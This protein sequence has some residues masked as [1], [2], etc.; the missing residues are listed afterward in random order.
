M[1]AYMSVPGQRHQDGNFPQRL[2][3]LEARRI[4]ATGDIGISYPLD[5]N[6]KIPKHNQNTVLH[7]LAEALQAFINSPDPEGYLISDQPMAG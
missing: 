1:K 2:S 3:I 6:R 7:D 5:F 4:L